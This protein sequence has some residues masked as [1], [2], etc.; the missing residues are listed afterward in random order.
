MSINKVEGKLSAVFDEDRYC[1][2]YSVIKKQYELEI[3]LT[4]KKLFFLTETED[5]KVEISYIP[6]TASF[7]TGFIKVL[8]GR[9]PTGFKRPS[10]PKSPLTEDT[11]KVCTV[12]GVD[13]IPEKV[14]IIYGLIKYP[15]EFLDAS[16]KLFPRSGFIALGGCVVH[17]EKFHKVMYCEVCRNVHRSWCETHGVDYGLPR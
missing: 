9:I 4:R 12:H 6:D 14:P 1:G 11:E 7:T 2:P 13:L 15:Q 5:I 16:K 17:D 3:K 8:T 10:L